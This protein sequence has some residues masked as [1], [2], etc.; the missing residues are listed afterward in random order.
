M[1]SYRFARMCAELGGLI[2]C[3]SFS[4]FLCVASCYATDVVVC[5]GMDGADNVRLNL[6]SNVMHALGRSLAVV[7]ARH[8]T[9]VH[10]T[11]GGGGGWGWKHSIQP[12]FSED[13]EDAATWKMLKMLL[14]WKCCYV[15]DAVRMKMLKML[16]MLLRWRCCYTEVVEDV[17]TLRRQN[18]LGRF[19]RTSHKKN[20]GSYGCSRFAQETW[21]DDCDECPCTSSKGSHERGAKHGTS[22]LFQT[23]NKLVAGAMRKTKGRTCS[24]TRGSAKLSIRILAFGRWRTHRLGLSLNRSIY[25][26]LIM[27]SM[28]PT[29]IHSNGGF[30]SHGVAPYHPL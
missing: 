30:L 11:H 15:E 1:A 21:P 16:K 2:F 9:L 3:V 19:N 23:R 18:K 28:Y 13:F 10:V 7:H 6:Y 14:L 26:W 12:V 24:L 29:L 4:R 27:I 17:A 25:Q 8:A 5:G 22:R 20:S